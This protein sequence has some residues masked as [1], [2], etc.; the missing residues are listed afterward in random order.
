MKKLLEVSCAG[1]IGVM[2]IIATNAIEFLVEKLSCFFR[3]KMVAG[4]NED[5]F[6]TLINHT[7]VSSLLHAPSESRKVALCWLESTAELGAQLIEVKFVAD[8]EGRRNIG[9]T[10]SVLGERHLV[11]SRAGVQLK[12]FE[13]LHDFCLVIVQV[14]PINLAKPVIAEPAGAMEEKHAAKHATRHRK[15]VLN[16]SRAIDPLAAMSVHVR[17][18]FG[19][20]CRKAKAVKVLATFAV[21]QNNCNPML[22][23]LAGKMGVNH[24][25][26]GSLAHYGNHVFGIRPYKA[27]YSFFKKFIYLISIHYT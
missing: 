10:N 6:S 3:S 19:L 18:D 8:A 11:R 23:W 25:H 2:N 24:K 7:S 15:G 12:C 1:D 27:R 4:S 16:G 22:A 13:E 5:D 26:G 20:H 21:D 9:D 17:H 14:T